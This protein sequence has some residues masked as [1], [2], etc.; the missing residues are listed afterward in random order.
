MST[1]EIKSYCKGCV[2]ATTPGTC[3]LERLEKFNQNGA[4]V[5]Q[6]EDG[7]SIINGRYCSALRREPWPQ[8]KDKYNLPI[9]VRAELL[10]SSEVII[11]IDED[12]FTEEK[13]N[14]TLAHL[15]FQMLKPN[16]IVLTVN[17][18]NINY[19]KLIK[20]MKST[21]FS[22][23]IDRIMADGGNRFHYLDAIDISVNK[24]EANYYVILK[25]GQVLEDDE[26]FANVDE[27][28]NERLE[29]FSIL[30]STENRGPLVSVELHKKLQGNSA[31]SELFLNEGEFGDENKIFFSLED[32]IKYLANKDGH[33]HLIKTYKEIINGN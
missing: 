18:S 5:T 12:N 22:Y 25:P 31:M 20:T 7:N 19:A 30:L 16:N 33:F 1:L 29:R 8:N 21:G 9:I 10:I 26:F 27:S 13:L 32:K 4:K 17:R 23:R 3:Q 28:L 14:L 24:S 15:K 6:D 2:F 11:Y